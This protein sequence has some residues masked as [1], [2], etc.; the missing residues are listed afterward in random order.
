[1][2]AIPGLMCS[3][4]LEPGRPQV[5]GGGQDGQR[6]KKCCKAFFFSSKPRAQASRDR[7]LPSEVVLA[8]LLR[9][10]A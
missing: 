6:G 1:M 3:R 10:V 2:M 5:D 7:C 9:D 4:E 8:W